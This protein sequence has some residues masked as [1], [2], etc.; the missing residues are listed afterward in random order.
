LAVAQAY[1][2][3]GIGRQLLAGLAQVV[4]PDLN[5]VL[6]AS[7]LAKDYYQHV[8]FTP[9]PRGFIKLAKTD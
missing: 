2:R 5:W 1:W 3:Q 9:H 4:E 7:P 8:G 6:L